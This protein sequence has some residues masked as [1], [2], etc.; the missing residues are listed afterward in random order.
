M[1]GSDT[2]YEMTDSVLCNDANGLLL[3]AN[4]NVEPASSG[5]LT[6]LIQVSA[7]VC[8]SGVLRGLG[9]SLETLAPLP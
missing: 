7:S 1:R 4:E 5:L 2:E 6:T 8:F 3:V 9:L